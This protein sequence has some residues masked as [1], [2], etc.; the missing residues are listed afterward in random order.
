MVSGVLAKI[1][2]QVCEFI[3]ETFHK[4][5]AEIENGYHRYDKNYR[6]RH[7]QIKVSCVGMRAPISLDDVYV[8][9]Q[10]LDEKSTSKYGSLEDIEK[11]FLIQ[12]R[13]VINLTP[14]ERQDGTRIANN[15]QYLMVLGGPG[16]GKS[17]FLRKIGLEA[18]KGAE[19]NFQH[20]CIPVFLEL[21]RFIE[22]QIDIEAL[23]IDEF[24]ICGYPHPECLTKTALESGALLLL[25]DGLDEVPT[26]NVGNVIDKIGDFVDLYSQNRFIA[27]C[28]V[29]AYKGGFKHFTEV[30]MAN[31]K[32]S[33]IE[34]YINNW[35]KSTS[36]QNQLQLDTEMKTAE[37]C[38][39]TLNESGHQATK[40]L[41]RNPL[42]LA[43]LCI[44]Y[45]ETQDFPRNRTGLYEKALTIFLERW[46]AEKRIRRGT[47]VGQYLDIADEMRMLS[48][49]AAKN[50]EAGHIFFKKN[51][52]IN[53]I[54][55]FGKGSINTPPT[56]NASKVLETIAIE[57][58]IFVERVS[59]VYSFSHLTFQ[60]YLTANYIVGDTRSIQG[61]VNQHLCDDQ[62]REV[63]LLTAGLMREADSLLEDIE[64]KAYKYINTD[65]LKTLFQW[66]KRI[67][68]TSDITYRPGTKLIF[69]IR[70][71]FTLWMLRRIYG[72]NK[73]IGNESQ[74]FNQDLRSYGNLEFCFDFDRKLYQDIYQEVYQN[75]NRDYVFYVQ[76]H[77][78]LYLDREL[79]RQLDQILGISNFH[80]NP[81]LHFYGDFYRYI[82][83]DLYPNVF[84]EFENRFDKDLGERIRL[85]EHMEQAK[86]FK[87]VDLQQ[88][89]RRFNEQRKF[90]KA[91]RKGEPVEI[92]EESMHDTWVSILGITDDMLA[93][94]YQEI[95]NYVHYLRA[96]RLIFEC[97]HAAGRVSPEVWQK[98]EERLLTW[99]TEDIE[100]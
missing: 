69:V 34:E 9:L 61:L 48:E 46:A 66:A 18:L 77:Q 30:E 45:D 19:G 79:Y 75:Q 62:W 58:G 52:L 73:K 84:S 96:M 15:K 2:E 64:A 71:F 92:P 40:E 49:I 80:R 63:F 43:M 24:R 68:D 7:G 56:F 10:F 86:I 44:V 78:P 22:K 25:F 35:F 6:R 93:I 12:S 5:E 57:Q 97:K 23:I 53:Q 11:Q 89:I 28:R 1:Y 70:Q 100:G 82:D 94:S 91:V 16:A 3:G 4:L 54:K 36:D 60:E 8:D 31:F 83:T 38:W 81:D 47:S 90:I 98:I 51:E 29:A 88:M 55:R 65:G 13:G 14:P 95:E 50:F 41:A 72:V 26:S 85:I 27:S 99:D 32:D 39:E 59:G 17:T 67:I 42:L 74:D 21:K 87:K 76:R 37:G 20:E 33:Q